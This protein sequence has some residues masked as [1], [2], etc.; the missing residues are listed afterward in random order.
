M[1]RAEHG[2]EGYGIYWALVE[3]MFENADTALDQ[4]K[5]KGIAVGHNIDI[6]L[7][8]SVI[9]TCIKEGLFISDDNKFWSESLRRRKHK[10]QQLKEKKS[11][12]GKKGMAKRWG[13]DNADITELEDSY[14]TDIT[15]NNK[16]KERKG[17]K[18][19]GNTDEYT[20]D[21]LKFWEYY[22]RSDNKRGA[23]NHFKKLVKEYEAK[24]LIQTAINYSQA[25]N[26]IDKKF[27]KKGNNFFG[28]GVYEDY[29]P[30][31]YKETP[32]HNGPYGVKRV[33]PSA[34]GE[35]EKPW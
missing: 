31:E 22:P 11:E 18:K 28:D 29:L 27:I 30:G 24:D 6:T 34:L 15:K 16:G 35:R 12:A 2:W 5:I 14:N 1:L 32:N 7:L 3:M 13:S 10:Y 26:G 33:D 23:F 4:N 20:D 9:N 21:F 25:T 17:K 19:K 8:Q